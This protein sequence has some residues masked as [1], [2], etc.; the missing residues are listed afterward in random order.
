[1]HAY[2]DAPHTTLITNYKHR[3]PG[4]TFGYVDRAVEGPLMQGSSEKATPTFADELGAAFDWRLTL[5]AIGSSVNRGCSG[6]ARC[7]ATGL[8]GPCDE[9]CHKHDKSGSR[10]E[11]HIGCDCYKVSAADTTHY[12]CCIAITWTV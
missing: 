10:S 5:T 2:C 8:P 6:G 4:N 7:D 12:C 9:T 3:F 11:C 1:M